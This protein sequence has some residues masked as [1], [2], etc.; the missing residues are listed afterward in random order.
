MDNINMETLKKT[1][2]Y[3]EKL[4]DGINEVVNCIQE[5]NEII[6]MKKII[7]VFDGIEYISNAVVLTKD[8]Q[9]EIIELDD[10]NAQLNEILDAFENEDYILI[11]DL[12]NYELLPVIEEMKNKVLISIN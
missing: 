5:G 12:L 6:G 9:K 1:Y 2:E 11:G 7:S 4:I 8:I 10:L 3:F